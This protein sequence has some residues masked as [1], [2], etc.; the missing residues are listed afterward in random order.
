[1]SSCLAVAGLRVVRGLLAT[2]AVASLGACTV[3]PL[4]KGREPTLPTDSARPVL[5]TR[6][7]GQLEEMAAFS[8]IGAGP[9]AALAFPAAGD[10]I[11]AAYAGEGVLRHWRLDSSE[12]TDEFST[13]PIGLGGASFDRT[14]EKLATSAGAE[15]QDFVEDMP[16]RG[17]QIWDTRSGDVITSEAKAFPRSDSQSLFPSIQFL[18]DGETVLFVRVFF[19]QHLWSLKDVEVFSLVKR[20]RVVQGYLD[21]TRKLE[22][23]DFDV[24]AIDPIGQYYAVADEAGKVA[25]YEFAWPNLPRAPRFVIETPKSELGPKPLA[26]AFDPYRRWLAGVR[27]TELVVWDLQARGFSH[28]LTASVGA[29]VGVTASLAFDPTGSLLA[30][31]SANG[32]QIWGVEDKQVLAEMREVEVYA[33][34]FSPDGQLFVWGDADGLVHVWGLPSQ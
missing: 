31:G 12:L 34:G 24:V 22:E 5:D 8:K 18:P 19:D 28:Q 3:S 21:A 10:G 15:W 2:V 9:V 23:D 1:M 27:G 13:Y 25:L 26:L 11:L 20:P 17:W 29:A 4:D 33:V 7:L 30:V 32:W 14:A 6:R 16:Y